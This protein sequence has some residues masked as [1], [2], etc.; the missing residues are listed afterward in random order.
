M[1]G[2]ESGKMIAKENSAPQM[3]TRK[4]ESANEKKMDKLLFRA[5][6]K[7]PETKQNQEIRTQTR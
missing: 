1:R 6:G 4:T 2:K 5:E 7:C 3:L